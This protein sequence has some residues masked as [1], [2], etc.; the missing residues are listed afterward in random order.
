MKEKEGFTLIELLA[1]IIILAAIALIATPVIL[2]IINNSQKE[3]FKDTAYGIIDAAK[4]YYTGKMMDE[5][6]ISPKTFTYPGD[7]SL[8]YSGTKPQ[9]GTVKINS[10]GKI[11]ITLYNG[12]YCVTKDY[13]AATITL[14]ESSEADCLASEPAYTDASGANA[15]VLYNHMIPVYYSGSNWVYADVHDTNWYDYDAKQW[16]NAVVL[17]ASPSKTYS[18]GD[19]ILMTDIS[20][21]Y[22]W[23][24]RYKYTIFNGNNGSVAVQ[25][26]NIAFESGTASTG[27][28]SCTN[29]VA[30]SGNSSQNCTDTTNVSV[31]N[32]T[33]TYTHPA[34]T[35]GSTSLTGIWIGKFE[36]SNVT[37]CTPVTEAVG[38]SC[39]L[40]TLGI[41]TKPNVTSWRG[42]RVSTYYTV[43]ASIA[44]NYSINADTHMMKNMEWGALSY[45]TQSKYGR[46][47]SGTCT[48]I[49]INNSSDKYTGRSWGA[50][51]SGSTTATAS[52]TY[53]YE[54]TEGQLA[55]TTGNISGVYDIS[56][57][58]WEYLMAD[59]VTTTVVPMVGHN[60]T[61][62]SGFNGLLGDGTTFSAG[63]TFPANNKYYDLYTFGSVNTNQI[64]GKLG[65]ATKETMVTLSN[66][67]GGWNSDYAAFPYK[68][69]TLYTTWF[70]RG[71]SYDAQAGAGPFSYT[72]DNGRA[73]VS[74]S[75]RSA[76][77]ASN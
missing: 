74:T 8:N 4:Y 43:I 31:T 21:M 65:D 64:R 63:R 28:V 19:T 48:E 12:K 1:V 18:V 13:T 30:G 7:S 26:I 71:G 59:V 72:S 45:L 6:D 15:P 2:G 25:Q 11:R 57:G 51:G 36:L 40:T 37:A 68:D 34:F 23:I 54:T 55:S 56:G 22:V 39:D 27:T 24:P 76:I 16:A 73:V 50:P 42:A 66:I 14:V 32:N 53:T 60:S 35:F 9:S 69:A 29:A 17:V 44:A 49:S 75:T 70:K 77:T 10:K 20:Q 46:C 52:G 5:P 33:S 41:Q 61:F 38:T 67:N 58:V 47:T 3:A 62:N